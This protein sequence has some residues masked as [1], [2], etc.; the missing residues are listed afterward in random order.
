MCTLG[1]KSSESN[2]ASWLSSYRRGHCL[3]AAIGA[4]RGARP[5][6]AERHAAIKHGLLLLLLLLL[7]HNQ[8]QR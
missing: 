1:I 2:G 6:N 5:G 8:G 7:L 4:K 3:L